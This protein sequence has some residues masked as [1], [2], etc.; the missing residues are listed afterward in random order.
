MNQSTKQRIVGTVVLL[1]A[2]LVLLPMLLDGEGSYQP[3]LESRIPDSPPFPEVERRIP[4][5]PV[6]LADTPGFQLR[7]DSPVEFGSDPA[8]PDV[9]D[10]LDE[11]VIAEATA[12]PGL[13]AV[14]P[15]DDAPSV[16]ESAPEAE[17]AAPAAETAAA[18]TSP[19]GASST[20]PATAQLDH[21][22]LPQGWS[23]RLGV[24]ANSNNAAALVARLQASDHR[25]Y[26]RPTRSSQGPATA[27]FVG[28]RVDR[29]AA[30]QL[31]EQ[32][33]EEFELTGLIV[34][35]EID[36]L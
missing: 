31:L 15:E 20:P 2:A 35:Y 6:V 28:P 25:A 3:P 19:T 30:Q 13:D 8:R 10:V 4:E 17:T 26:S 9:P 27:V 12:A 11:D 23:V 14:R 21:Q 7:P 5:R 22:G 33:R 29:Q 36:D 1:A 32:L 16:A 24:F 18:P 34:P